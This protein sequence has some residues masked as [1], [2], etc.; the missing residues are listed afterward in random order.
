MK[1][2]KLVT[3][4]TVKKAKAAAKALVKEGLLVQTASGKFELPELPKKMDP[5]W[6]VFNCHVNGAKAKAREAFIEKYGR[7][8]WDEK[9]AGPE[10]DGIMVIFKT[11]PTEWT[12]FYV[13][14][15]TKFVNEGR[16]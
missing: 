3:P 15:V 12:Q 8:V 7:E 10:R 16:Y 6:A 4:E 9:L 13:D 5:Y 11:P 14:Q 1:K 2:E